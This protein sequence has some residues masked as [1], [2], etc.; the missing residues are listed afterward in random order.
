MTTTKAAL[1][2]SLAT[3]VS[4]DDDEL[5]RVTFLKYVVDRINSDLEYFDIL[6]LRTTKVL[7]WPS[8]QVAP[9]PDARLNRDLIRRQDVSKVISEFPFHGTKAQLNT[10]LFQIGLNKK[11]REAVIKYY[12][13]L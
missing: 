2:K 3:Y 7:S 8:S 1:V 11:E 4:E 10:K 6:K 9:G 12:G 5:D 13:S